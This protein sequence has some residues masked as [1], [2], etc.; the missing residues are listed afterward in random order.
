MGPWGSL[1]ILLAW[2]ASD[3]SSNLN[4]PTISCFH[5]IIEE[6]DFTNVKVDTF[7]TVLNICFIEDKVM[8]KDKILII[9]DQQ[10]DSVLTSADYISTRLTE[11]KQPHIL[12]RLSELPLKKSSLS[13]YYDRGEQQIILNSGASHVNLTEE[14][15]SV[16]FWHPGIQESIKNNFAGKDRD[17]FLGEWGNF[18]KGIYL[19]L[20]DRFWMNPY[21][22]TI[23]YQDK[24]FQLKLAQQLGFH[25]PSTMITTSLK[26]A[27]EHFTAAHYNIIY[28]PFT[29]V[30]WHEST[31]DGESIYA[32]Y[33]N[34]IDK[35]DL[36]EENADYATPSIF[37]EYVE[38][39]IELRVVCVGSTIMACEIHSQQSERSKYDWRKYD[40]EN[41]P[42]LI[43]TLPKD[44]EDL[45]RQYL[46]RLHLTYG[47]IDLILT[48]DN[49]YVFL[50][51]N[52]N[53]QFGFIEEMTKLP[54]TENICR[55]LI[56]GST[57]YEKKSW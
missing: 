18:F 51:L 14:V 47:S 5:V 3:L 50:E 44:I 22:Q 37:Q 56:A 17:F 12:L 43:H 11:L 36:K 31:T 30:F 48:P 38:K 7:K 4:G 25:I 34:I 28:K 29:Q 21:P 16:L 39:S 57:T 54:I 1:V 15:K 35:N 53:G 32:L 41:T 9:A 20:Q 2:G 13:V 27:Q 45:C 49:K 24:V 52:P 10:V 42:Y 46:D 6:N 19:S 23:T 33:T 26:E 40:F 8:T 55:M